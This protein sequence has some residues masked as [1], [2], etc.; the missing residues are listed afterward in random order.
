M[1]S[2][3]GALLFYG[4]DKRANR[5]IIIELVQNDIKENNGVFPENVIH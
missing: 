4:V 1:L 3:P 5:Q 2:S